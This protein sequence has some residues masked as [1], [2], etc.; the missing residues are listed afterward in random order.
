[1]NATIAVAAVSAATAIIVAAFGYILN[2]RLE[3]DAEWRK[4]QLDDI[5]NILRLYQ[6]SSTTA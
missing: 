6:V 1:M 4:L 2:K 3:R 5:R